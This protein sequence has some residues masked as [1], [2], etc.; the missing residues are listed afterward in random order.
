MRRDITGTTVAFI[1]TD[2]FEDSEL[3]RP[4]EAVT[5]A[6]GTPV[7]LAPEAGTVTGKNGHEQT[8]DRV[9]ADASAGDFDALVLPGGVVN[10]DHLRLHE[11]AVGFAREIFAQHKPAGVICHGAWLLVE[12]DVVDDRTMT[13]YPSL[14]TD[15]VNAGA[16]WVDEE[17]VVDA[18]FVTS[19]TPDDL[20]AFCAKV[21]EEIREGAHE[22]QHA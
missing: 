13:S 7:L 5:E 22:R 9:V 11:P 8:V 1:V 16:N 2:G 17:V 14:R 19:R 21:V 6:G 10:A 20:P 18:G 12:A 3:T 4:W 15:L